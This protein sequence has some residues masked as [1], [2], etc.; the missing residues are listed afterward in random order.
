M[1]LGEVG[2]WLTALRGGGAIA[3][4]TTIAF[5]VVSQWFTA[6]KGIATGCVTLGAPL[7]GIFFSLVLQSLFAQF[8]WK[9]A[10]LILTGMMTALLVLGILL[11]ETNT[12]TPQE[13][14]SEESSEPPA[15]ISHMLKSPKFWLI[16]Y[17]LFGEPISISQPAWV[18][19]TR[20]L[21]RAPEL[22]PTS[23]SSSSNGVPSPP[24]PSRPMSGTNNS[25]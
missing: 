21:T 2:F 9:V 19:L 16:S 17:A 18:C 12:T 6:R 7:G 1:R 24:M 4:P 15:E 13:T 14:A 8:S 23:L 3:T 22:Q 11:V 25:T 10:A 5:S 20:A